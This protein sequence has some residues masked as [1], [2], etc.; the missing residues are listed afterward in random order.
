M[1]CSRA[2]DGLLPCDSTTA[3][4]R[5]LVPVL[6]S[7]CRR[8]TVCKLVVATLQRRC[9]RAKATG[10][11]SNLYCHTNESCL[12]SVVPNNRPL[13]VA[14]IVPINRFVLA[15]LAKLASATFPTRTIRNG[16][17]C[18]PRST[19]IRVPTI[20]TLVDRPAFVVGYTHYAIVET[21]SDFSLLAYSP[22]TGW[23]NTSPP[24][25][26]PPANHLQFLIAFS[27]PRSLALCDRNQGLAT[28]DDCH[29]AHSAAS[30]NAVLQCWAWQFLQPAR[31]S[32]Q[33]P[34]RTKL[35]NWSKSRL[36]RSQA[37]SYLTPRRSTPSMRRSP[38]RPVSGSLRPVS[39]DVRSLKTQFA[40]Q[41]TLRPVRSSEPS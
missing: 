27:L 36:T 28:P 2:F 20:S 40:K 1:R 16:E 35:D 33:K 15:T 21:S 18:I 22:A 6:R 5:R 4:G 37:A 24:S 41:D 8:E 13:C 31:N 34:S 9:L 39:N 26:A 14:P 23:Q 17:V 32:F 19:A 12:H 25:Q 10:L 11:S 38:D 29:H 7:P 3:F 30:D